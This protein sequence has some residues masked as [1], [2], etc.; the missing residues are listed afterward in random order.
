M[1]I[2]TAQQIIQTATGRRVT[3][4]G[5]LML[6]E[7]I[8]GDALRI[9]PEAP[10]PVVQ[11]SRRWTAPGG[12][13]NVGMNL[14]NLGAEVSVLGIV[15]DD[16]GG[17]DLTGELTRYGI[18]AEGIIC[19]TTRPTTQKTRIMAQRQQM[20]RVDRETDTPWSAELCER[21]QQQLERQI[22]QSDVLCISDYDKGLASS[23]LVQWAI[24]LALENHKKITSGPKPR[25]IN[26]F[27]EAEFISLN[28][29]EASQV[30]GFQLKDEAAVAQAGRQL[31]KQLQSPAL[32]ITRGA[33]GAMLFEA[34]QNPRTIP[35]H[36]VEVFDVAGAGD[37]F[38]AA[39]TLA[40]LAG[41][42]YG[43]ACE[44]GNLAAAA[45]V[46]H[47]GVVAMSQDDLLRVAGN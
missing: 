16:E 30:A 7:W 47:V 27:R 34:N 43:N 25:N 29:K 18:D 41:E 6:D 36:E 35:A 5:D 24:K 4:L 42:S 40:I 13:A 39:A 32:A 37:T 22:L 21:L 20:V 17:R 46:R 45:S 12:A 19:D 11:F 26:A 1:K 3:V 44:L 38:L 28:E 2:E 9:S 31:R 10:V 15:G 33:K 14:K 23:G 8:M